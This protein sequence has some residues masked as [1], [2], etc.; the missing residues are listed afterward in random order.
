MDAAVEEIIDNLFSHKMGKTVSAQ[1]SLELIPP[2]E[3]RV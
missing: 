1:V 3:F 2:S